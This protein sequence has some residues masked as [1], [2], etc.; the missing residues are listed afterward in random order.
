MHR[1][2][3]RVSLIHGTRI[4]S[5]AGRIPT[6]T[7]IDEGLWVQP[8]NLLTKIL[9]R[10]DWAAVMALLT[11]KNVDTIFLNQ[12]NWVQ[13]RNLMTSLIILISHQIVELCVLL[14]IEGYSLIR[15]LILHLEY[16]VM[17]HILLLFLTSS[18]W[19]IVCNYLRR[20]DLSFSMTKNRLSLSLEELGLF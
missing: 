20:M 9:I 15:L 2:E 4:I 7:T 10:V 5:C 19:N 11:L 3:V 14:V 13:S 18:W 6:S 16:L 12:A 8:Q 17:I 1:G